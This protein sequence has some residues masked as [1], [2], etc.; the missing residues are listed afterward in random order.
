MGTPTVERQER[1]PERVV[2]HRLRLRD[3]TQLPPRAR[4]QRERHHAPEAPHLPL[5]DLVAG[6]EILLAV[7]ISCAP[8]LL[9]S[10]ASVDCRVTDRDAVLYGEPMRIDVFTIFPEYL[11]ALE[12]V[13]GEAERTLGQIAKGSLELLVDVTPSMMVARWYST[14]SCPASVSSWIVSRYAS[15]KALQAGQRK[16]SQTTSV[17]LAS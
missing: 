1:Q 6:Q 8:H 11:A 4:G 13:A 5:G 16:S 9:G 2:G 17:D 12:E 15:S 3:P 7:A 10:T 14:L